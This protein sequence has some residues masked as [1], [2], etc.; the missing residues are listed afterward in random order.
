MGFFNDLFKDNTNWSESELKALYFCLTA[1]GLADGNL[2]EDEKQVIFNAMV[3]LP[4]AQDSRTQSEWEVFFN[5]ANTTSP[6]QHLNILKS[7]H[8][9][10]KNTALGVLK[11][12]FH[13]LL[14]EGIYIAPSAFESWFITD[15]LTYQDLDETIAAVAKVAKTL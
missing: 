7:M 5:D 1:M 6:S 13:G 11:T 12:F 15:A 8:A 10:K 4:G 9:K 14:N 3:N 2:D